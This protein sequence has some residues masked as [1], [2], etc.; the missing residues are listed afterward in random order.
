MDQLVTPPGWG[1]VLALTCYSRLLL[2][3]A[4]FA[5]TREN[6]VDDDNCTCSAHNGTVQL[7]LA[8][9]TLMEA[10]H[11][12]VAQAAFSHLQGRQIYAWLSLF[13]NTVLT[14]HFLNLTLL[15]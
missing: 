8:L 15:F 12:L 9:G 11:H 1:R 13:F 7:H 3:P 6:T 14:P 5:A 2:L 4:T 10:I